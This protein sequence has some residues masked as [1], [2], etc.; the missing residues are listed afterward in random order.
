MHRAKHLPIPL[1]LTIS[2]LVNGR[3][4]INSGA[5]EVFAKDGFT[6]T[7]QKPGDYFGEG[8]L[9]NPTRIRSMGVRCKTPVHAIEVSRECLDK[10]MAADYDL[11]LNLEEMN[12]SRKRQRTEAML[13]LKQSLEEM[14]V[15]NGDYIF[16]ENDVSDEIYILAEGQVDTSLHGK[17][18]FSLR[19]HGDIFG[20]RP[21]IFGRPRN[22]AAQCKSETCK[23]HVLHSRDLQ[24]ILAANPSMK[25]SI[26]NMAFRREFQKAVCL[27]T[28]KPFP[29][30]E[31]DLRRAFDIVDKNKSGQL[32]LANIR[33]AIQRL[34]P[35]FSEQDIQDILNSLDLDKSGVV[36]WAEFKRIFGMDNGNGHTP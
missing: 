19:R 30:N 31:R 3:Y 1:S 17:K 5:V 25:T 18:V 7:L 14:N 27:L 24:A 4:F 11:K 21:L 15:A 12:N 23:L 28:Q 34:D 22:A 6:K 20:E 2:P 9:I 13:A 8:A 16:A 32:E 29:E 26:R 33:S 35:A 36:C 10:Y